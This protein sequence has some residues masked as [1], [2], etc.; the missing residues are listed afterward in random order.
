[1]EITDGEA[2]DR[3][4]RGDAD[5]FAV[6]V[7]RYYDRCLRY[8]QR[9]L[10]DASD[11]ADTVQEAF[12]RAYRG[13]PHYDDRGQFDAWLFRILVNRCRTRAGERAR[14]GG[15]LVPIDGVSPQALGASPASDTLWT[16]SIERA[17]GELP[18]LLREAFVLKHVE[19]LN[20]SEMR[21]VT[22]A[23]ESALKMRVKRACGLLR[24][25]LGQ[26]GAS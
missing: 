6:V 21:T 17:L 11:A 8:A 24:E 14:N 15:R 20:Y 3:V 9:F 22:G 18:P 25:Q 1:M 26:E 23:S 5:A 13:L 7:D 19:G 12:V 2:L 4:R 10:G 16:L